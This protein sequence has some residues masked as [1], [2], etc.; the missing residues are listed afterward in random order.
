MP[1]I[2]LT[3]LK[4][5]PQSYDLGGCEFYLAFRADNFDEAHKKHEEI[6]CI[7][8]ENHEMGIHFIEAPTD[9]DL[10]FYH[11]FHNN[12]TES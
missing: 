6:G 3:W 1:E 8:F 10:K 11:E 5:H 9:I 2:K 4:E 12:K 7:C